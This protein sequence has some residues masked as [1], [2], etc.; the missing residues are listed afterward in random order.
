MP[1][2]RLSSRFALAAGAVAGIFLRGGVMPAG[3]PHAIG[4]PA[5]EL[6]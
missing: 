5:T 1:V 2:T 4:E 3:D 6:N